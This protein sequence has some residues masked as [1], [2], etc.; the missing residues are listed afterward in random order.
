[1][2]GNVVAADII[3][4]SAEYRE[5]ISLV[6]EYNSAID[7]EGEFFLKENDLSLVNYVLSARYESVEFREI[8]LDED[9]VRPR[10]SVLI[11]GRRVDGSELS[12]GEQLILYIFW[13]LNY[14]VCDSSL[15]LIE[16]PETGLSPATQARLLDILAVASVKKNCQIIIA[17]H[18]PFIVQYLGEDNVLVFKKGEAITWQKARNEEHL[19]ELG[20]T[21][22]KTHLFVV[23]D[24]K[25]KLF[26]QRILDRYGSK[27]R[28]KAEILYVGGEGNVTSIMSKTDSE[29]LELTVLG[30][31]DADQKECK[32]SNDLVRSGRCL[33]LPGTKAPEEEVISFILANTG[34][35][36]SQLGVRERVLCDAF[37]MLEGV[38]H[39]DYFSELSVFLF[40]E[41]KSHVYELA[42]NVWFS[43][44]PDRGEIESF[45]MALDPT[46]CASD[47]EEVNAQYP[48]MV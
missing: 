30:V 20:L 15:L 2:P 25:A 37:R 35:F 14:R 13:R 41:E 34:V 6:Y 44:F 5:T 3:D 9:L 16:E 38:N 33:F 18:S 45:V 24:N 29:S 21:L 27:M 23:E 48:I 4:A 47:F 46:L 17:T 1:M 42:F 11:D 28:R 40:G 43:F 36:A 39:H 7:S 19:Q 32:K 31:V 12:Y 8:E 22:G 26:L 10:F